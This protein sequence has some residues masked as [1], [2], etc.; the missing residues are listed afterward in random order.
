MVADRGDWS[1]SRQRIWGVPIPIFYCEECGKE[2]VT[3]ESV[4]AVS[5][6][7]RREGSD[8]W[9]THE[10]SE[11]LLAGT[12]CPECGAG[13][14]RKEKDI[15][16]VWFD[17]GSSHAA[18]L[19][20]REELRWPAGIYLEG[21]DQHRGWFQSSLLTAVATRGKAP[22]RAVLTHG[23]V[24]DGEGRKMSKSLGNVIYPEKVIK[25]YGA[26][27]LRLW[28]ASADYKGDIR[29]SPDILKQLAEVYRKI[30]NTARFLLGNL[31][32]FDPSRDRARYEDLPEI[33]RWALHQLQRLIQRVT[34]AYD[35]YEYH[36]LYHA[37]HNF[38][39]IDLSSFYL[40]VLKDRLY[41]SGTDSQ[42]RRAAQTVLYDAAVALVKL[43][44]PVL[45]FTSEE[46]WG[47][48]PR[49]EAE[50]WSVQLSF[51][52][53]VNERYLDEELEKRWDVLLQVRSLVSKAL[54]KAR[55]DKLVGNS[56]EAA[57]EVYATPEAGKLLREYLNDLPAIF[58]VS[59]VELFEGTDVAPPLNFTGDNVEDVQVVVK[60]A[61]GAKCERCWTYS[62]EVGGN[63]DHPTLCNRCAAVVRKECP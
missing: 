48:L 3:D 18:V 23:F 22:Y 17:S 15:M 55:A 13:R 14:F 12:K 41:T 58:I 31:D 47:Y 50:P 8:A 32:D 56:L 54:E 34:K 1:I 52:P 46:I 36:L 30:R 26:D 33:D 16:D 51:W 38:C 57:V 62:P 7:F 49:S 35:T 60:K 63:E 21:S 43:I 40:D 20:T 45:T 28:V 11:I 27:I 29:V 39:T 44:A 37:I 19:E 2:L 5:D 25:E 4:R 10:A 9:Y 53:E 59:Q 6:L 61:A 24:V 42:E